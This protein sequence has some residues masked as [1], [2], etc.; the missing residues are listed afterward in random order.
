MVLVMVASSSLNSVEGS[1]SFS[2]F[3]SSGHSDG[4]STDEKS[5]AARLRSKAPI[6]ME[7]SIIIIGMIF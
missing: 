3:S 6:R 1:T 2:D 4:H 5:G 7:K